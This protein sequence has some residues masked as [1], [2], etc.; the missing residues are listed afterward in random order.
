MRF[1][2]KTLWTAAVASLALG[3]S[4]QAQEA[5]LFIAPPTAETRASSPPPLRLAERAAT[6]PL[7]ELGS[8]PLMERERLAELARW[9]QSRRLP[10]KNGFARSLPALVRLEISPSL[11]TRASGP[12]AGGVLERAADGRLVWGAELR[13]ADAY[14]VRLHLSGAD[15]PTGTQLW[16][17]GEQESV[18]PFGLELRGPNGDLWTPSVGGGVVRLEAA[19][20]AGARSGGFLVDQVLELFELDEH[21]TPITLQTRGTTPPCLVDAQCVSSST[22]DVVDL[23]QRAVALIQFIDGGSGFIC[24]GG[25][26]NDQAS[27]GTPYFLTANHCFDNQ[28]AATTLEAF[29]DFTSATCDGPAPSINSVPRSNG[30]TLLATNPT[31]D[32]TFLRLTS[33]PSNRVLLGWNANASA[34]TNGTVLNRISHPMGLKQ[35]FSRNHVD[36]SALTCTGASRPNFIYETYSPGLGDQGGTFGGSSGSPVIRAGGQVV[37]QLT[38]GC[39]PNPSDGCDYDNADVD[40]AFSVTFPSI[41]TFLTGGGGNLCIEDADTA[42]LVG[43]RFKVEVSYQ[44]GPPQNLSGQAM[45]APAGTDNSGLFYFFNGDNWEMLLKVLDACSLNNRFWV[46]Y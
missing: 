16:V 31:S 20:P 17:Y 24:S 25:L 7:A 9:N 8:A 12:M 35:H 27:S 28:S 23:A 42:C 3:G 14:R 19:F 41:S 46:F 10:V 30:S 5:G 39:G 44:T 4:L 34:V 6:A 15:L 29:W 11:A 26:I 43:N 40:G 45:V 37:G 33:I 1:W 18:G 13:V 21:G 36:T 2:S 38:G 32:F 22:F